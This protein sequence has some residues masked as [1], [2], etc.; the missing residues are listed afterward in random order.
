MLNMLS[1]N[2]TQRTVFGLADLPESV[3]LSIGKHLG[4]IHDVLSAITTC[5]TLNKAFTGRLYE[6][7]ADSTN[8]AAII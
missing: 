6:I 4:S 5:K 8:G 7:D 2:A 1:K 3:L